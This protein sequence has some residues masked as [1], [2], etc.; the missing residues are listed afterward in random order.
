MDDRILI[1]G[2]PGATE[3]LGRVNGI[4]AIREAFEMGLGQAKEIWD[5]RPRSVYASTWN[6]DVHRAM[7]VLRDQDIWFLH[8]NYPADPL[9][10]PFECAA[11]GATPYT[12]M[13]PEL[14]LDDEHIE[15]FGRRL[16]CAQCWRSPMGEVLVRIEKRL[17]PPS[18]W[19][20]LMD[21]EDT[22]LK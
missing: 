2:S 3:S 10:E 11:C 7:Q 15:L 1:V 14:F 18:R 4:K 13:D 19:D 9:L 5:S 12:W 22:C 21:R 6:V 8:G 16:L 17:R 20:R